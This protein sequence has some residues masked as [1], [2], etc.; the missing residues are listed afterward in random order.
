MWYMANIPWL[1]AVSMHDAMQS[2]WI[3]PLGHGIFAIYHTPL[4]LIANYKLVTNV[5]RAVKI[6][7]LSYLWYTG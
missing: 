6:N 4:C 2:A 1:R 5:N 3:Q 7:V